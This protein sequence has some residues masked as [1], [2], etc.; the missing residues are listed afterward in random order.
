MAAIGKPNT[1][2]QFELERFLPYRLSLLSNTVSQ[3]IAQIYQQTHQLSVTEW[4]IMAVLGRYPGL[5]ASQLCERT[6]MDKVS[7]SRGVSTLLDKKMVQRVTDARDRRK[8]PLRISAVGKSVLDDVIP[9]ALEYQAALL[10]SLSAT[11]WDA[12]NGMI[13]RLTEA[14]GNLNL[15]RSRPPRG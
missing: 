2:D 10:G 12:F 9:F 8:R 5:T 15:Q 6:V 7:I 4:R 1:A 14:A 11:E 13:T 3:G